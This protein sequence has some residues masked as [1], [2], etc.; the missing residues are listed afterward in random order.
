MT[1]PVVPLPRTPISAF[2]PAPAHAPRCAVFRDGRPTHTPADLSQISEILKEDDTLVWLDV[3][4]PGPNDLAL[5]QEEFNLHPLAVEDAVYAHERPK[6][7]SY[8]TYWFIVVRGVTSSPAGGT[9]P[10]A[11]DAGLDLQFHEVAIFAG[12]RFLVTVRDAPPY[13]LDEIERRWL[14]RPPAL[15]RDSGFLLY[16]I[17]DTIIDGYFPVAGMFEE[18]VNEIEGSLL[19]DA[20]PQR[21]ILLRMFAMK[22]DLQRF[23]QAALPMRE[24]LTPIIRGDLTLFSPE[25]VV[26]YRDVYDHAI[27]I[28]DQLDAARDQVNSAL[29]IHL[30]LTANRQNEVAKQLTLIATI[31]LPLT[32]ITGFFGQNFGFLV[33]NIAGERAF[34]ALGIGCEIVALVALIIYFKHKRWY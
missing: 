30:S 16:T 15:R 7:E 24:I 33:N 17:L 4:D 13:P 9:V 31:F 23:R 32:F 3:V 21:Y 19:G 26:Y 27:R 28:I 29:D 1:D 5:L 34:W 2:E 6:I 25:E 10:S 20:P 18:R 12:E 22:R 14:T 8:P 11:A